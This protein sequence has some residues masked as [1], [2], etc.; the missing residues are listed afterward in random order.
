MESTGSIQTRLYVPGR[1][2]G[3]TDG[4]IAIAMTLLVFQIELPGGAEGLDLAWQFIRLLPVIGIYATSFFL[5]GVYWVRHRE[6]LHHLKSADLW[7]TW[8][9]ILFLMFVALV[10]FA[11]QALAVLWR[12]SWLSVAVFGTI[13]VC[14]S[15]SLL[16]MWSYAVRHRHLLTADTDQEDIR[17]IATRCLVGPIMFVLVVLVS[18]LNAVAGLVGFGLI[19]VVFVFI[20]PVVVRRR[21]KATTAELPD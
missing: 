7:L 14:I 10:P 15:L 2:G 19:L 21:L 20:L 12:D 18:L 8:L 13:Q 3:L 16:G 5:L 1:L 9:N 4:V 11:S 6:I 17:L